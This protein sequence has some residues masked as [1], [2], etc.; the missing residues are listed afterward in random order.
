MMD[1]MLVCSKVFSWVHTLKGHLYEAGRGTFFSAMS[2]GIRRKRIRRYT[3]S[4]RWEYT[5]NK[6]RGE[7]KSECHL[8]NGK[9]V[10]TPIFATPLW[11]FSH[12]PACSPWPARVEAPEY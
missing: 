8:A 7:L 4:C 1:V 10:A 12:L 5:K 9:Y 11:L 6:G 2:V 3:K